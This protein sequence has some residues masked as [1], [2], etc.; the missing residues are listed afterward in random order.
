MV[1]EEEAEHLYLLRKQ[2]PFPFEMS[3]D[4]FPYLYS[5]YQVLVHSSGGIAFM[6]HQSIEESHSSCP[7]VDTLNLVS[8]SIFLQTLTLIVEVIAVLHQFQALSYSCGSLHF[9]AYPCLRIALAQH[10]AVEIHKTVGGC[11]SHLT[12]TSHLDFLHQLAVVSVDGIQSEHHVLYVVLSM[13]C[14]IQY[15]E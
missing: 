5:P 12:D 13:R 9:I 2:H 10:Y 6:Q 4:G 8:V 7:A 15:L 14:A 3:L 11:R 1:D